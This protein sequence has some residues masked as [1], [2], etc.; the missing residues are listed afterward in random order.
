VPGRAPE[1]VTL[2]LTIDPGPRTLVG[3]VIIRGDV[4]RAPAA[5]LA[6]L[7]LDRGRPYD[8]PD[9]EARLD[10]L[11]DELRDLGHYEASVDL[12]PGFSEDGNTVNVT[13]DVARGPRVR[14]VFAG[15]RLP[16]NRRETLVPI[17]QERSVD[18]DLLEDASRNIESFLRDQ[19]YRSA[20]APYGR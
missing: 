20:E 15:D 1:L 16:E 8:R 13:V 9:I 2:S 12:T 19:G 5:L 6:E 3:D 7:H 17:R 11:E 4:V 10:A 18:L 14:V